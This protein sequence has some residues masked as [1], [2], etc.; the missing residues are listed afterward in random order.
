M[1]L[2]DIQISQYLIREGGFT[3]DYDFFWGCVLWGEEEKNPS[4]HWKLKGGTSKCWREKFAS[5]VMTIQNLQCREILFFWAMAV[6]ANLI[7]LHVYCFQASNMGILLKTVFLLSVKCS[8]SPQPGKNFLIQ[9]I[10]TQNQ[11]LNYF[12]LPA[13]NTNSPF[14]FKV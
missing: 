5:K 9:R 4:P 13:N 11:W 14:I 8:S 1:I 6:F 2:Q 10:L 12:N 7:W 3:G